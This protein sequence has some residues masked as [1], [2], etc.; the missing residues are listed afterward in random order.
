[1]KKLFRGILSAALLAAALLTLVIPAYAADETPPST[2]AGCAIVADAQTGQILYAKNIDK[3]TFSPLPNRI[4]T[5]LA[6]IQ[7]GNLRNTVTTQAAAISEDVVPR[8]MPNIAAEE[9]EIFVREDLLYAVLLTGAADAA[10]ILASSNST[11]PEFTNKIK[12]MAEQAGC[13]ETGIANANGRE[14]EGN[15]TSVKD[16]CNI[17]SAAYQNEEFRTI[18]QTYDYIMTATEQNGERTLISV[19]K[20]LSDGEYAY[21]YATGGTGG[22]AKNGNYS[23]AVTV[24]NGTQTLIC[25]LAE[26]ASPESRWAD[27]KALCEYFFNN[28]ESFTYPA[29]DIEIPRQA[30]TDTD[31][32]ITS[33]VTGKATE[34]I[35]FLAP[36]STTE[37]DVTISVNYDK[38]K[39]TFVIKALLQ[40]SQ[41]LYPEAIQVDAQTTEKSAS[42]ISRI[43]KGSTVGAVFLIAG[44]VIG[45]IIIIVA[46]LFIY[47]K[48]EQEK[49]RKRKKLER[50]RRRQ[51]QALRE[52]AESSR[53]KD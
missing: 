34:D 6:S 8:D 51:A 53:D 30:L 47:A 52:I 11:L 18:W 27:T 42:F 19:C 24:D 48:I 5:V 44:I 31:G 33:F 15:F 29:G 32:T 40:V 23:S 45:A 2:S 21:E 39:R 10:N 36:K 1:M 17:V 49:V 22:W 35:T 26:C 12:T 25:V 16:I 3:R 37:Q 28:Y 43:T 7:E 46:A 4:L 14:A 9:N 41:P 38:D 20:P 13:T 50:R